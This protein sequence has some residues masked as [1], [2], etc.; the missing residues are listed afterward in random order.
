M[1]CWVATKGSFQSLLSEFLV[2]L[3]ILGSGTDYSETDT[4]IIF[5]F[6]CIIYN[7]ICSF[8]WA[9]FLCLRAPVM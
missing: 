8:I 3:V 2:I 5:I 6:E 9:I 4:L 1:G 7:L